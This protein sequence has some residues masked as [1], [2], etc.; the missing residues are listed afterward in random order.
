MLQRISNGSEAGKQSR[1]CLKVVGHKGQ[2]NSEKP[3]NPFW[4][5][6]SVFKS[7]TRKRKLIESR[8]REKY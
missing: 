3:I 6:S 1:K 4:E 8:Q 7:N 5:S 2:C